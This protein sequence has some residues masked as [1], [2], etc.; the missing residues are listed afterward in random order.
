MSAVCHR[1]SAFAVLSVISPKRK[2]RESETRD[3]ADCVLGHCQR[4]R[5]WPMH[6]SKRLIKGVGRNVSTIELKK[7]LSIIAKSYSINWRKGWDSNP[8]W[9]FT[10]G[11]FQDRCLK[12]LGHPSRLRQSMPSGARFGK[13][14]PEKRMRR[15]EAG[16]LRLYA[17]L[18]PPPALPARP[19]RGRGTISPVQPDRSK[20]HGRYPLS[21]ARSRG[22]RALWPLCVAAAQGLTTMALAWLYATAALGLAVYMVAALLRPDRF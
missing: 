9:A 13:V 16:A 21:R 19:L 3:L 17:A 12:P 22:V 20:A 6:E 2:G 10:H 14:P 18:M 8:R 4:S 5:V 11:G 7:I 1:R 15:R